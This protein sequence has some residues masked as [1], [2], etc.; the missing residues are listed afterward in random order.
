MG[1]QIHRDD[2]DPLRFWSLASER[3]EDAVETAEPAPAYEAVIERLMRP[4]TFGRFF[5]LQTVADHIDDATDDAPVDARYT[6]SQRKMR[7]DPRR[8]A[9]AQQ[10]QITLQSSPNRKDFESHLKQI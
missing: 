3:G 5:P 2:H 10:K 4:I 8:L 9:R 1:L 6:V 7:R